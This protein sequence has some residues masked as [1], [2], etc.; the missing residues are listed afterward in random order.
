MRTTT[1]DVLLDTHA[2]LWWQGDPEQLSDGARRA[3]AAA[4]EVVVSAVSAWEIA[5]LVEAGRVAL[6]RPVRDWVRALQ[7]QPRVRMLEL[8]AA[9]AV[10]AVEL[11]R[12]GFPRDPADRFLWATAAR[13][14]LS[15]VTKDRQIHAFAAAD[16]SVALVW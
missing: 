10:D 15:L 16:T 8:D 14:R 1:P 9:V 6:D 5:L 7:V 11:A 12:R 3:V 13:H 2:L 4:A